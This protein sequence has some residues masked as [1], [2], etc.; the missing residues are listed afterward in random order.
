MQN[1]AHIHVA[2]KDL[3]QIRSIS[4]AQLRAVVIL[5]LCRIVEAES[6]VSGEPILVQFNLRSKRTATLRVWAQVK[7]DE[8]MLETELGVLDPS[9]LFDA[10][11]VRALAL[12]AIH[13]CLRDLSKH[14]CC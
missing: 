3:G 1:P 10:T 5:A 11:A 9:D 13:C 8:A 4:T 6:L 2:R 7:N 12:D 14:E